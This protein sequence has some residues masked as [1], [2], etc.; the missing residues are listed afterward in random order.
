MSLLYIY[1]YI[2]ENYR[3]LSPDTDVG[4]TRMDPDALRDSFES[5]YNCQEKSP[6]I[7]NV[8]LESS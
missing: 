7:S 4:Q 6:G 3:F 5:L 2:A 1:I 8:L